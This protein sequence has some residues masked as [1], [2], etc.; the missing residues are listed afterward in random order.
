MV[1]RARRVT[2]G[3]ATARVPSLEDLLLYACIH[4]GWG[5]SFQSHAWCSFSD[6]HAIVSD[7]GFS[8]DRFLELV[9]ATR[10]GS[11]C[12]WTLRL[13][14]SGTRLPVPQ[15]VLAALPGPPMEWIGSAL[16]R[17]FFAQLFDPSSA[18]IPV[19]LRELLW[20]VAIRPARSGLGR[21]RPWLRRFPDVRRG[22]ELQ[23]NG[24]SGRW[25]RSTATVRYLWNL[26]TP[27]SAPPR[28]SN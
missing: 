8:W 10:S 5:H 13:A 9:A 26:L 6:A 22:A 23:P 12:Y 28:L 11:C 17:H 16:E 24:P 21:A 19:R 7:P 25:T 1:G 2:I 4:F 27:S 14:V 15:Q 18:A 3:S 20:Q